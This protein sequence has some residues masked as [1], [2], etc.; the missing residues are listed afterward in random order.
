MSFVGIEFG[1]IIVSL[2]E[3]LLLCCSA[4]TSVGGGDAM[5]YNHFP[6][7]GM[8]RILE[9]FIDLRTKSCSPIFN[10]HVSPRDIASQCPGGL[11]CLLLPK[12]CSRFC[13]E[14]SSACSSDTC[15]FID[16]FGCTQ[17]TWTVSNSFSSPPE[18][19]H[20]FTLVAGCPVRYAHHSNETSRSPSQICASNIPHLTRNCFEHT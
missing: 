10:R 1:I 2:L 4:L 3:V 13:Q 20:L 6:L 9:V 5:R 18:I 19:D 7:V 11:H 17:S 8:N 14:V 12:R 16:L 15:Y